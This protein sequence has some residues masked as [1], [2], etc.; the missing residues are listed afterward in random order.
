[1]KQQMLLFFI[2][3]IYWTGLMETFA[4]HPRD[5]LKSASALSKPLTTILLQSYFVS[6]TMRH[7]CH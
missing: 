6:T 1:M 7:L 3:Q 4:F 2:I 5:A